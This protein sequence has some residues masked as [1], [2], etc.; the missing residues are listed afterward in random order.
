ML[1]IEHGGRTVRRRVGVRQTRL[2]DPSY[3]SPALDSIRRQ[4]R[5]SPRVDS[6]HRV[7]S[8]WLGAGTTPSEKGNA[9]IHDKLKAATRKRVA[10]TGEPYGVARREVIRHHQEARAFEMVAAQLT[11]NAQEVRGQL[12]P[13]SGIDEIS[14][15]FALQ[16][17]R[18][19]GHSVNDQP[20]EDADTG[21]QQLRC[22]RCGSSLQ[23]DSLGRWYSASGTG[24]CPH[25]EASW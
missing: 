7:T 14:W 10:A 1:G 24:R 19:L 5:H 4:V 16:W 18:D 23:H 9:M 22:R 11:K 8:W 20:T 2:P 17:F 6:H 13:T 3:A 25:R 21:R 12:A 15:R